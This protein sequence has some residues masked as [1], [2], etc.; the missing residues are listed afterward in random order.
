[1]QAAS[2]GVKTQAP[3][4][5]VH[6]S[7]VQERLSLQGAGGV[8]ETHLP[9]VP[10]LRSQ[11]STP[12]QALPSL[13]LALEVHDAPQPADVQACPFVQEALLYWTMQVS[14]ASLH[15]SD[16]QAMTSVGGQLTGVPATQ[17]V[18]AGAE[19]LHT[20]LPLQYRP[21]LQAALLAVYVHPVVGLQPFVVH[22]R[23]S[24]QASGVPATQ[25]SVGLQVSMPSQT[26]ELPQA[27]FC[28]VK[29]HW[30]LVSSQ[31]FVVHAML[32]LHVGGVPATQPE[33]ADEASGSHRS[34]PLQNC[35]SEQ[36]ESC[37]TLRQASSAS[38]QNSTV[39]LAVSAG[40]FTGVPAWHP[41]VGLHVS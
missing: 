39:Q 19:G 34:I 8:P 18:P 1:M 17:P 22:E 16:V 10:R 24:S 20:S 27:E 21:S 6:V 9:G 5:G 4:A 38:S 12:L 32:S 13:Q 40:Q 33:G 30:S 14:V 25:P 23:P 37:R 35:E 3:V 36:E 2:F 29:T 11:V 31:L 15:T 7:T 41:R 26:F 28:G